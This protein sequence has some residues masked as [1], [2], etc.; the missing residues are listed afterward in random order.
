MIDALGRPIRVVAIGGMLSLS[1]PEH[2]IDSAS[3]LHVLYQN[4]PHSFNY[5]VFDFDGELKVRQTFDYT[6]TRPRLKPI[7]EGKIV[8]A[9]GLRRVANSDVPPAAP[10]VMPE[11]PK[12]L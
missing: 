8:V 7:E 6:D 11:S 12:P 2:L 5:S 9:G 4:G 3:D 1:R 10:M